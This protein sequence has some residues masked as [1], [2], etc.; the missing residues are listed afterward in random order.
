MKL[1]ESIFKQ[2]ATPAQAILLLLIT[3][4]MGLG[5]SLVYCLVKQIDG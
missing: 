4:A 5:Y 1:F 2:T 3:V